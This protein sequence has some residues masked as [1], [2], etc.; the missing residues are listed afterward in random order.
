VRIPSPDERFAAWVFVRGCGATTADSAQLSVL[1]ASSGPPREAGNA[2]IVEHSPTVIAE[3]R[4]P[5]ELLVS[6]EAAGRVFKQEA[7]VGEVSISYQH[8]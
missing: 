5:G 2:L 7:Q 3:W 1:P 4:A 8:Q 6:Y